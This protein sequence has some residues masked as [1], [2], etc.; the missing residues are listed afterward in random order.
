M[1]LE[2]AGNGIP[3]NF[4]QSSTPQGAHGFAEG[5]DRLVRGPDANG[6]DEN[7]GQPGCR[8]W[9]ATEGEELA[10]TRTSLTPRDGHTLAGDG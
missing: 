1:I 9:P 6:R 2:S 8:R 3:R 7:G 4:L 10:A 5:G